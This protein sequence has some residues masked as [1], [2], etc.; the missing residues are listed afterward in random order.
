MDDL[1]S[2]LGG[3][4]GTGIAAR[5]WIWYGRRRLARALAEL[6]GPSLDELDATLRELDA[7]KRAE[8]EARR[9]R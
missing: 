9:G 6:R 5:L 3:A 2:A 8:R 4:L 1:L 7:L